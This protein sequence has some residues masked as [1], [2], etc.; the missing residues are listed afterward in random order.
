MISN[1]KSKL[2]NLGALKRKK[3]NSPNK[4]KNTFRVFVLLSFP[5]QKAIFSLNSPYGHV[6]KIYTLILI[7]IFRPVTLF[8]YFILLDLPNKVI[9]LF[10]LRDL[11]VLFNQLCIFF[12][13]G[14]TENRCVMPCRGAF[15][16]FTSYYRK[17]F[18]SNY[19]QK[20]LR[21]KCQRID[22]IDYFQNLII[23]I[24]FLTHL[25]VNM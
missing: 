14:V 17:F 11:I 24:C 2:E 10:L 16:V 12:Q 5:F 1:N 15:A 4:F 8:R 25:F 22:L 7:D 20:E 3:S 9:I 18:G 13:V 21:E 6:I 19:L 23:Q